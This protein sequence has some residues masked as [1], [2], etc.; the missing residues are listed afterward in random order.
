M[1]IYIKALIQLIFLIAL[2]V[3][4][5]KVIS[6]SKEEKSNLNL[7]LNKKLQS[8]PSFSKSNTK[9]QNASNNKDGMEFSEVTRP[10]GY[11]TGHL[12]I[13]KDEFYETIEDLFAAK[14]SI[15]STFR[16]EAIKNLAGWNKKAIELALSELK[17]PNVSFEKEELEKRM[18]LTDFLG[19]VS[20][21]NMQVRRDLFSYAISPVPN[22]ADS[23]FK[24]LELVDRLE[25][26]AYVA[27][28]FTHETENFIKGLS[29]KQD[30]TEYIVT[31][32]EAL[33]RRGQK[34]DEIERYLYDKF[35]DL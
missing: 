9:T 15:D 29:S 3:I 33:A 28:D 5:V 1:R 31:Y 26:F 19:L 34:S 12:I 20:T 7:G 17:S 32:F 16:T 35:G 21:S 25:A 13:S 22:K 24:D 23:S 11:Q 2:I 6:Y 18:H 8:S 14:S 27:P 4:V 10:D 30:R